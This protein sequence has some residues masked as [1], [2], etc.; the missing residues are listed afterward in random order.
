MFSCVEI[1]S[2]VSKWI[3]FQYGESLVFWVFVDALPSL[4]SL[5]DAN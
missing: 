5:F 3:L 4:K 1:T 2:F